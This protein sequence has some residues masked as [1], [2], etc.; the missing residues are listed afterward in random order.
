MRMLVI[1][2]VGV[3]PSARVKPNEDENFVKGNVKNE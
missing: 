3:K 2:I 1:L